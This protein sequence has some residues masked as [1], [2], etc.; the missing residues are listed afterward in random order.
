MFGAMCATVIQLHSSDSSDA[1]SFNYY[2]AQRFMQDY[3]A[4]AAKVVENEIALAA[5]ETEITLQKI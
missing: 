4:Q 5:L 1:R 3:Q 2:L